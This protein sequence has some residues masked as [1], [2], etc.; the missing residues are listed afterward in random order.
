M[1]ADAVVFLGM[2]YPYGIIRHFALLGI[3]LYKE[4]NEMDYYF[5]SIR[6]EPDKGAWL[7]AKAAIPSNALIETDT[8]Q[9]LVER[10]DSL[11]ASYSKV[12]VHC[13]GGWGQT[14]ALLPLLK[15][16]GKRLVLVGTTHSY[17]NDS[18]MRIP[19]SAFQSILYLR[20]YDKIIFQ[21]Q[22]AADKFWGARL[23]FAVGKGA[24]VP[25][26]CEPFSIISSDVPSGIAS[27]DGL[28]AI[29]QDR[30][31][32]KFV[33]LAG[34][35]PGKMHVW[36]LRALA[37]VLRAHPNAR[38]LFCG[39]GDEAVIASVKA[40]IAKEMLSDQ[41]LLTGQIDR[42]EVP[43][44]LA[45]CDCAVV[46]SR[47][48]T[49][50]HNFLE[51]MFAGLP[52]LGTRVGI[53]R[54]IIKDGETGYGFSLHGYKDIRT[55]AEKLLANL[56][57]TRRMGLAAKKAVEKNFTHKSVAKQL[58]RVYRDHLGIGN[59]ITINDMKNGNIVKSQ[60]YVQRAYLKAWVKDGKGI[61]S[62]SVDGKVFTTGLEGVSAQNYYYSFQFLSADEFRWLIN[63]VLSENGLKI[64]KEFAKEMIQATVGTGL[65]NNVM[66]A[67]TVDYLAATEVVGL[68]QSTGVFDK[69]V[70]DMV[71]QCIEMRKGKLEIDSTQRKAVDALCRNGAEK[72]MCEI[73]NSAAAALKDALGGDSGKI[74]NKVE[75]LK[76]LKYMI[77]QM[78]RGPRF[79]RAFQ[80]ERGLLNESSRLRVASYLRYFIAQRLLVDVLGN[81]DEAR[82]YILDNDVN[83]TK[84]VFVTG[85]CPVVNIATDAEKFF[86]LFWPISPVKALLF[87]NKKR[88]KEYYACRYEKMNGL[89]VDV[90]NRSVCKNCVRNVHATSESVLKDNKYYP[91]GI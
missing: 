58:A 32:F 41:I 34:F 19:M 83:K 9:Q 45:H 25:L 78:V 75:S 8:F 17:R 72:L 77:Y 86:D 12:L 7:L 52:V 40:T 88:Y 2:V 74:N 1:N 63:F 29:L 28:T 27:K 90:L 48:E 31:Q 11:F 37:P 46:P 33:Y 18:A 43:W 39:T 73:E 80:G 66:T 57:K 79:L 15:R 76:L 22:Y 38:V 20:Y 56:A 47:A 51:P 54:D 16:H 70:C 50:G 49:F 5:A 59:S 30:S 10:I 53:G 82:F 85:D 24:I 23:L 6:R 13:G 71:T 69:F 89:C 4:C 55:K 61:A 68:G 64:P 26:G 35:R 67:D 42:S 81:S 14:K 60:H 44:L 87:V 36:L 65:L 3:E 84:L 91:G 21:C 62:S